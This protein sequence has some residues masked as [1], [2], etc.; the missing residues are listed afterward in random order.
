[1]RTELGCR[2]VLCEGGGRLAL[3]LLEAGVVDEFRLHMAPSIMGDNEARPLFDGR[4]PLT[5]ADVLP[6]RVSGHTLCGTD[7]HLTLRPSVAP[8][9]SV[10]ES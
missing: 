3:S 2:Y 1:M 9:P 8:M 4:T 5:M 6:L 10:V 7:V